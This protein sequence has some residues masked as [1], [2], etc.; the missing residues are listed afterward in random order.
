MDGY[1][2]SDA[3]ADSVNLDLVG[4][5]AVVRPQLGE[6][7]AILGACNGKLEQN[8]TVPHPNSGKSGILAITNE[9][10]IVFLKPGRL[11]KNPAPVATQLD[12]IENAGTHKQVE[13]TLIVVA[14]K[15]SAGT[16]Y[17]HVEGND[18]DKAEI[19]GFAIRNAARLN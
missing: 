15:S 16:F 1:W 5:E 3:A 9:R 17:F 10:L 2:I 7:E 11:F 4:G 12:R 18:V 8:S 6:G 19:L 14:T 13:S